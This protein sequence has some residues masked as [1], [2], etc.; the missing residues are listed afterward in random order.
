MYHFDATPNQEGHALQAAGHTWS[1]Y[2]P[3][4]EPQPYASYGPIYWLH[5]RRYQCFF[6]QSTKLNR[7]VNLL[8]RGIFVTSCDLTVM[9]LQVDNEF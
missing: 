9:T 5:V 3:L 1:F 7:T 2:G 6:P 8:M 4:Q